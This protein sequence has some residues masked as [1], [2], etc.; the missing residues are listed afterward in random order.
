MENKNIELE[1]QNNEVTTVN[2][3]EKKGLL[4]KVGSGVKKHWK[5]ALLTLG[6][7][8]LGFILG[9]KAVKAGC[10]EAEELTIEIDD[11][12]VEDDE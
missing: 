8:A 2:E 10:E 6:V 7:G 1:N 9:G 3:S 5:G 12:A 11:F 4:A